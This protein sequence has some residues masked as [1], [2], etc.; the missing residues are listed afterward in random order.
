MKMRD[1]GSRV[2]SGAF[3]IALVLGFLWEA[4][5]A[6]AQGR[7]FYEGKTLKII[8]SSSAGGGTDSAGRLVARFLPKHLPGN[9]ATYVQ[10]MP[11][12][13]GILANNYFFQVAKPNGLEIFQA[14]SSTV[15]QFS[16]GGSRIRFDPREF[17]S[18]GSI[19]RGGSIL[20]IRREVHSRLTDA[21]A[22]PVVVGDADGS[23]TWLAM[24]LWGADQLGWNCRWIYGYP[25]TGEMVLAFRQ[26]E[27][28]MMATANVQIVEDLV[29]EKVVDIIAV[30]G[31]ERRKD[32][33]NVPSFVELLG[34]KRPKGISWQAYRFWA[35]PEELDKPLFAPPKTPA[36]IMAM[37]EASYVKM[38][39]DP[40]FIKET[41]NFYG[42]GWYVRGAKATDDLVKETTT[43]SKE[44]TD[45]LQ[46]IR[47]KKGLPTGR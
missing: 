23:R 2:L 12:G 11:A 18:V 21:R 34:D 41:G 27:I 20:M 31:D 19:N 40:E 37:L 6:G 9:P 24:T 3:L 13:G 17:K 28:E 14:S 29:K 16:R 39:K 4:G 47:K 25:G 35:G 5:R 45:F 44:V 10:N 30:T 32:F 22:K 33:P 26:G 7:P 15:T 38:S 1:E 43:V 42:A 46:N 36:P 8:V